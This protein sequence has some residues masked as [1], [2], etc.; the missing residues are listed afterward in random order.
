MI[1]PSFDIYQ[2]IENVKEKD[3][4]DRVNLAE[5]EAVQTWRQSYTRN[6]SLSEEQKN[7]ML[8]ENKLLKIVDYIRYGIVH[9]DISEIDPELLSA[10]R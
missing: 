4:S 3:A 7:G 1:S 5:Q 10:I 8:Y 6:G 2:F 9:R